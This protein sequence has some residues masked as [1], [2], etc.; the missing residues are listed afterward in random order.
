MT[1]M[2]DERPHVSNMNTPSILANKLETQKT[3]VAAIYVRAS[4]ED[5]VNGQFTTLDAQQQYCEEYIRAKVA[6]GW[7]AYPDGIFS[8]ERSGASTERPGLRRLMAAV[9]AGKVQAVV[10]K[11]SDRLSR[12]MLD[13]LM[14][15]KFFAE[16]GAKFCGVMD[17]ADSETPAGILMQ[18]IIMGMSQWERQTIAKRTKDKITAMRKMGK[19]TGS[20]LVLGYNHID[21][22]LVVNQQE[23]EQVR[24]MFDAYLR[25]RS[26]GATARFLNESGYHTKSWTTKA[27]VR[28]GGKPYIRQ[29]LYYAL[30]SPT[31]MGVIQCNGEMVKGEHDAIIDEQTFKRVQE[32]LKQNGKARKSISQNKHHHLLKG[33]VWCSVCG[34]AMTPSHSHGRSK[35]Y[36]YYRCTKVNHMGRTACPVGEE[37]AEL[38]EGHV[39]SR[40]AV[41]GQSTE[42]ADQVVRA[43]QD[44]GAK[45]LPPL[46]AQM[47][48]KVGEKRSIAD[49]IESLLQ[50]ITELKGENLKS[51]A[52]KLAELEARQ[53]GVDSDIIRLKV[54]IDRLEAK[55]V[56]AG[57]VRENFAAFGRVFE[58]LTPVEQAELVRLVVKRI[59]Y[60]GRTGAIKTE[61]R[62]LPA[63]EKLLNCQSVDANHLYQSIDALGRK[64]SNLG[65]RG[66]KPRALPLGY[67]PILTCATPNQNR[68]LPLGYAPITFLRQLDLDQILTKD[69]TTPQS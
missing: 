50:V 58:T 52:R 45:E 10:A 65:M 29:N 28:R 62:H 46:R 21:K 9:V 54:E 49:G 44:A 68:S 43:S 69:L 18:N 60:D 8:D 31:Y 27:G 32:L 7:Q 48:Q 23:A 64:D 57:V 24:V 41:L 2:V 40:L 3:I 6:Q 35:S 11:A 13:G 26:L 30:T 1:G 25:I 37:K 34:S 61:Y 38:L 42:L 19:W 51:V 36:R 53:D 12:D 59:E 22:R 63:L 56:D 15:R 16:H 4:T 47:A 67:T 20:P 17:P 66:S 5:Q 33:L 14:L 55:T 39:V